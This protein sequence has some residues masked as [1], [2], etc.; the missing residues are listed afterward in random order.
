MAR[1]A[2]AGLEYAQELRLAR[3]LRRNSVALGPRAWELALLRNMHQRV[4]VAGRIVL[5]RLA[6]VWRR[7]RF[8]IEGLSGNGWL[9]Y[10]IHQAVAAYPHAVIRLGQIRDEI[11]S[12]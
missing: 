9:L 5:G 7:N 3:D 10:G 6:G 2:P 11:A 8:Q 12:A 1:R 4:P